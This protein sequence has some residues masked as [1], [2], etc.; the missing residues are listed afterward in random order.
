MPRNK[1][2][3]HIVWLSPESADPA[4]NTTMPK[5]SIGLRP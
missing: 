3:C 2:S 4:R 5:M 1:I